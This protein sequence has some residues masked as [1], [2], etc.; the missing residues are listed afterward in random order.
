MN[1]DGATMQVEG[2]VIPPGEDD[3]NYCRDDRSKEK[4]RDKSYGRDRERKRRSRF[5]KH[6]PSQN[7]MSFDMCNIQVTF[8]IS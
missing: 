2:E 5:D 8:K 1:S 3:R 7:R 6:R 4:E